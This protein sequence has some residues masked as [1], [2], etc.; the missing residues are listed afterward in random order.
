MANLRNKIDV[1]F[2]ILRESVRSFVRHSGA[3]KAAVLAYNSFFALFAVLLLVLFVVGQIMASSQAAMGAVERLA[4]QFFPLGSDSIMR[5]VRGL[6]IQRVWGLLSLPILF[7]T[8]APLA[9]AIRGAFDMAY[10]RDRE[11]PFFKERLMDALAVFLMLILLVLLVISEIAYALVISILAGRLPIVVR[12]ADLVVPMMFTI[13]SLAF[14]HYAFTPGKP[15]ARWV[16][17]GALVSAVLLAMIGPIMTAIIKFNPNFGVAFGS[18]KAVFILLIWVYYAFAAILIGVEVS[19]TTS[20][21]ESLLV[22]ELF[23]APDKLDRNVRRLGKVTVVYGCGEVIFREGDTGDSMYFVAGGKVALS[24]GGKELRVMKS[25]E[26]FGEMA[27]LSKASR[28]ATATASC[29]DTRLVAISAANMETVLAQN[30]KIVL[31][32]LREMAERLRK[33]DAMLKD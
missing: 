26:Y 28:T 22:R 14:L 33:T 6:A 25:G 13:G 1:S 9:A 12:V 18:L 24:R 30:P 19:A 4:G 29:D 17:G 11:L 2:F 10:G 8:V 32:L 27:M 20:R 3:E 21:R 5:E 23:E 15:K 16:L 31:T 7:W